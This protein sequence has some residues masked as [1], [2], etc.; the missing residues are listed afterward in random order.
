MISCH[1]VTLLLENAMMKLSLAG[2]PFFHFSRWNLNIEV[3]SLRRKK[4]Y[5]N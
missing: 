2:I 3:V 5:K 4:N 1:L